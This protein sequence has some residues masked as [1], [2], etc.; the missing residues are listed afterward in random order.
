MACSITQDQ[1]GDVYQLIYKKLS[2]ADTLESFDLE[3]LIKQLYKIVLEATEDTGK[4]LQYA[5]AVPDIFYLVGND[6][7]IRKKLRQSKFSFDALADLSSDFE[8]LETVNTYVN[9]APITPDEIEDIVTD[10]LNHK[11]DVSYEELPEEK[12]AEY[13]KSAARILFPMFTTGQE[14]I[15]VNPSTTSEKNVKDPEKALFYKVI[16][17]IV[18]FAKNR[19]EDDTVTYAGKE[20]GLTIMRANQFPDDYR[21][22]SDKAYYKGEDSELYGVVTYTDGSPV[23]FKENGE[24]TEN[25]QDGRIIY[26]TI[27]KPQLS[28]TNRLL[29]KNKSGYAYQLLDAE[30]IVEREQKELGTDYSKAAFDTRVNEIKKAQQMQMNQLFALR[31]YVSETGK[32]I[33]TPITGGSFGAYEKVPAPKSIKSF[34]EL[35]EADLKSYEYHPKT[36]Y[37]SFVYSTETPGGRIDQT[38]HLKSDMDETLATKIADVLTSKGKL[39]GEEFIGAD[40]RTFFEVFVYN[41]TIT[42]GE[43]SSIEVVLN[44]NKELVV[45]IK[46]KAIPENVL[47]SE[48]G[49]QIIKEALLKGKV[50]KNKQG[51]ITGTY[52]LNVHYNK[53]YKDKSFTD[54]EINGDKVIA[55]EMSHF[56]A[57]KPYMKIQYTGD[58]NAYYNGLNA[59]LGFSLPA[60]LPADFPNVPNFG[61]SV[62]KPADKIKTPIK[63]EEPKTDLPAKPSVSRTI[64]KPAADKVIIEDRTPGIPDIQTRSAIINTPSTKTSE[65]IDFDKLDRKKS[66][67][68]FLDRV[69]TN[70]ADRERAEKWWKNSPLNKDSE[71]NKEKERLSPGSTKNLIS[72]KRITEVVNSD[73]FATFTGSG[74]TLYQADGGTAVDLYH[75]SWHAFSQLF[76]TKDEKIKLYNELRTNKKWAKADYI[77]IEEAIAED[78]RSYAKSKGKK[79]APKGFLGEVFKRIYAF[80]RNMFAKVKTTEMATRPRDI[81]SVRELYDMLYRASATPDIFQNLKAN[82]ENMMFTQ[83]NRLK[84]NIVPVKTAAKDFAPFTIDESVLMTNTIDNIIA[85]VFENYNLDRQTS[86][87][88]VKFLRS[89]NNRVILYKNVKAELDNLWKL[90]VA[91]FES[92]VNSNLAKDELSDEDIITEENAL[93]K[94]E[95][96]NKTIES[97]GDPELSVTGQQKTGVIA[98]HLANSK[99]KLLNDTFTESLEDPTIIKS[100]SGNTINSK[101][102]ASIE[103][104]TVL[105]SLFKIA[106]D[107]NNKIITNNNGYVYEVDEF[108]FKQLEDYNNNWN[109]L[110]KVLE[111]S[112]DKNEMYDRIEANKENYPEFI[113]LLTLLPAKDSEKYSDKIAFNTITK[114]WQD[115]KKPRIRYNQLNINRVTDEKGNITNEARVSTSAFDIQSVVKDWQYSFS[116]A[117]ASTSNFINKDK[118]GR[119]RLDVEAVIKAFYDP[120]TKGLKTGKDVPL[121][122]LN[123]IG[124]KLDQ[125][126]PVIKEL[127]ADKNFSREYGLQYIFDALQ[128]VYINRAEPKAY[129][130]ALNP[131]KNLLDG[132]DE[133][134]KMDKT[135]AGDV[136]SRIKKLAELQVQNSDAYSNFAALSPEKNRVWE[137]FV[138]NTITRVV[139]SLNYGKNWQE[140][141]R[142]DADP[143]NKFQHMR[144]LSVDNNTYTQFSKLINSMYDIKT[145]E[146]K[147][148][149][150]SIYNMAGTQVIGENDSSTTGVSTASMDATSKFLQ[151]MHTMLLQ[152]LEEFMRHASKQSAMGLTAKN[153]IQTYADKKASKLYVDIEAFEGNPTYGE[154]KAFDILVGY[155]SGEANRIFRFQSDSKFKNWAGYN[156]PVKRKDGKGTETMAGAAFT[157]FD[158]VLTEDTQAD[159]YAIIDKA[160]KSK[161][162]KFNMFDILSDNVDLRLKVKAD[163]VK[164]FNALTKQSQ[165]MLNK[166]KYIDNG[167]LSRVDS[168]LKPSEKE[169]ALLKAYNYNSWIHKFE[170]AIIAYGDFAQYN[171]EKEEFHKRNAGLGSGGGGFGVDLKDQQ[172]VNALEKVYVNTL[173]QKRK[174]KGLDLII[175]R[176][177]TGTLDTAIIKERKENSIY[178]N[179]YREALIADYT[180]R[181]KDTRQAEKLADIAL[182]EYNGMK[183]GDGQGHITIEAY[184]NLKNLEGK[185]SDEQEELYKKVSRGENVTIEDVIKYFPPYK[186]Q[187]FGNMKTEGL[188]L[189][190]FHKFSLAPIVPGVAKEGTPLYDLHEKMLVDGIDYV[191]FE[192]G[193][194]VGHIGTGDNIFNADNSINKDAVFTKNTIFAEYLK[195]QTE[196]NESYK[197]KS[198]FSTQMRK[199][200]L[201]GLYEQ[202]VIT[203]KNDKAI[204]SD[205]VNKYLNDVSEYTELL[206]LELLD[207]IGYDETTPGEYTPKDA[208]SVGKLLMLI[209]DNLEREDALSDDIISFIDATKTGELVND[210]SFHPEAGK[211]EKLLLSLINKRVIKQKVKGEP[212]IQVS[213]ALYENNFTGMPTFENPTDEEKKKWLGTNG[214]PTYHKRADGKTAAMKVMIAL[215][216]DYAN[217]LNLE[218]KGEVI[219][220]LDRLNQAIKDDEWLDADN[221]ANRKA[222]TLVGVRIPVQ[223]LNS[224]EFMEVYEFLPPQAGNIIIPPAEIVAKSGGDFDIDKLTIFMT[225]IDKTGKLK[226][227]AH[228][229]N[230]IIKQQLKE[231][232]EKGESTEALFKAQ[233]AG[234]EN[235]LIKDIKEILELPSNY[236]SLI[237]PNGTFLLKE[238]ADDLSQYVMDYNRFE[239]FMTE[240]QKNKKCKD[241]ISPTR[242]LENAYNIFKHESNIVGKKTLGLG[243]IENTFNVLFNSI[244]AYMP[245]QYKGTE[246]IK[247][248]NL[249]LRHNSIDVNGEKRISLSNRY[250]VDNY[251]KIADIFS[252][253]MNGWL[254]VE[255]DAWIF[256]IQGNYEVAPILTYL[257]KA[258]VPIKEAIYFV[259]QPLVREY[260]KEQ[261]EITSAYAEV[262]HKV[263]KFGGAK[264]N[265]AKNILSRRFGY[266]FNKNAGDKIYQAAVEAVGDKQFSQDEMYKLIKDY[267]KDP[268]VANSE[269]SKAMFLHFLQIEDQI[270][271]IAQIKMNTNPDT[272]LKSVIAGVEQTESNLE[273]LAENED[274]NYLVEKFLKDSVI[275]SFFNGPLAL[276]IGRPLFKLRYHKAISRYLMDKEMSII[277]EMKE[278]V[279]ENK[280]DLFS[281]TFRNDLVM[282][283]LQNAIRKYTKSDSYMSLNST[284]MTAAD[285]KSN[286]IGAFVKKGTLYI[287]EARIK[288]EFLDKAW[289]IKSEAEN[290]YEKLGLHPLPAGTFTGNKNGNLS[291]YTK[292]VAEREYL[293]STFPQREDETKAE[294]EKFLAERALDNTFNLF[295]LFKDENN[296]YAKRYTELLEKYP[297][298]ANRFE[299]LNKIGYDELR[300]KNTLKIAN[301]KLNDRDVNSSKANLYTTNIKNLSDVIYLRK[302]GYKDEAATEISQF[303]NKLPMYAYIQS[304]LN[305]T[306]YSL[307]SIVDYTDFANILKE[308]SEA[309][310]KVLDSSTSEVVLND[311]NDLFLTQNNI[312]RGSEKGRLKDY[313]SNLDFK[314]FKLSDNSNLIDSNVRLE[315]AT[316]PSTSVKPTIDTSREWKGDLESRPVYTAEGV[317]TMR[318]SNANAFENFGNPFSEAGYGNTIK[319]ESI[320]DAVQAYKDWLLHGVTLVKTTNKVNLDTYLKPFEAQRQW[321]LDQI[322]QGKLDGATLLYAGKSEARGQGMHPTALAEVVEQIRTTQPAAEAVEKQDYLEETSVENMMTFNDQDADVNYYRNMLKQHPDVIYITNPAVTD[323]QTKFAKPETNQAEFAKLAGEMSITIP[324]DL[325]P[326]DNMKT[327]PVDK[328]DDYKKMVERKIA[329]IK[330]AMQN[331]S[332]A[333][334]KA[335]YGDAYSMPQEL[336]VYLSKRLYEEFGYVNSGSAIDNELS[337]QDISD[338]EILQALG[339]E[340]DPFKC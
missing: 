82:A 332:V 103:T 311:F 138:D 143:N 113:Q 108:G 339:F 11:E 231:A 240:G 26:Q 33:V 241:M 77:D 29:F 88:P 67:S 278:T 86:T 154:S 40:K 205:I 184:R 340:S 134:L 78:F 313:I 158:D 142:D 297:R 245:A 257:A 49:K 125:G 290:S 232:K 162:A 174:D 169:T 327:F 194:K 109:R 244:G 9:P 140:L 303:F 210:L 55:K 57:I 123:A 299:V 296:N 159:L 65:K 218:Y 256:F 228:D 14:A 137:H 32:A 185:W 76:L 52:P 235:E 20:L 102:L 149:A 59:Y 71:A 189:T 260:V 337:D 310:I 307:T 190:S 8:N 163:V 275:S 161:D 105:S 171:H 63:T 160:S 291:E 271:G 107:E 72:L 7:E 204:T 330:T 23:Y 212:L 173:N 178:F 237:T 127:T 305:K 87:G 168:K 1:I 335:G 60:D 225:N 202:G 175:P 3:G 83:L 98:F 320:S 101:D 145:G 324:T 147:K 124:I 223:G 242:V 312:S 119:N 91:Q 110:A 132:L 6:S 259:S 106:R 331:Q 224:M 58:T 177:Y 62:F 176:D 69:F 187:Y 90:K 251:N 48:E 268:S 186:L 141:T 293:R 17:D 165:S 46:G 266:S 269:L 131:V 317:N 181:L 234:L 198:I 279:G 316:Q 4:A 321:I 66:V 44:S 68:N 306:P 215:Q 130:F 309:F 338:A 180:D 170:T 315:K 322:N 213:S 25:P 28:D 139:T 246:I 214:L 277:Q 284:K 308:E 323:I 148:N 43:P 326:G 333:F 195:N 261:R 294:Y 54:Y 295:H 114:F 301:L 56:D 249:A 104:V 209:R 10:I 85:D 304:G 94:I 122:F 27:R 226:E 318:T 146:K 24:I 217:L 2:G 31:K 51:N 263:P 22:E 265:A 112:F 16:R 302:L 233:K 248:V 292:F 192:S 118:L 197:G 41:T 288:Q 84:D 216:G 116:L 19:N 42:D 229:S 207:E 270:K 282:Y 151:E 18:Y 47:Y 153:G 166:A 230:D 73:A 45:K 34:T 222:I 117:D 96:L 38:I 5:Q 334:S 150:L 201:D 289:A 95:L 111:G 15:A 144:W 183:I 156:R 329:D 97:F 12:V 264:I 135:K 89:T 93:A 21:L 219:G 100:D 81:E 273:N 283:L 128:Q 239:T 254:D 79:E 37:V 115:L 179:E 80:L 129:E 167:L 152:G 126:S 121:K 238:I 75:E 191:L 243:A 252:Q 92:I 157:A 247:K 99:F 276:A 227:K 287:D 200:I 319:V 262:L 188:T 30:S 155:L 285:M 182:R 281:S 328:Y 13:Q 267:K 336:F 258:G 61:I 314:T 120:Q 208:E 272:S 193:S 250:D 211:I 325:R 36:G 300:D 236:V 53:I 35:S 220:T 64:T 274:L 133:S 203:T 70:K 298:L 39:N 206:K 74:I 280:R 286:V 50:K 255:K 253:A 221:G 199:L 136:R 172:Y 196:M 164:Y